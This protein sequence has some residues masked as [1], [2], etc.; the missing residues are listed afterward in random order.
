[1]DKF[2]DFIFKDFILFI[3]KIFNLIE[4][5]ILN[6]IYYIPVLITRFISYL[7][8]KTELKNIN[9]Q[10]FA[11]IFW[12]SLILFTTSILYFRTGVIR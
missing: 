10:F 8:Q 9:S 4:R 7:T 2:I 5:Y 3:A 6:F 11:I 1:M 12:I